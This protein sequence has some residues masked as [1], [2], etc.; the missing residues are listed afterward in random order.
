MRHFRKLLVVTA[1]CLIFGGTFLGGCSEQEQVYVPVTS[2]TLEVTEEGRLIAYIVEDF[3]KD[4]YDINELKDMVNAEIS[5]YN[6]ANASLST[7]AGRAPVIVDKVMMAEDGSRKAVVALNFQGI[8]AYMDYMG[9][10]VFF[11]TV[12]E[13]INAGYEMEGVLKAVKNGEALIGDKLK[14]NGEKKI[15][16]VGDEVTVRTYNAV[17]YLS[18]NASLTTNGYVDAT[19][20]DSLKYMIVK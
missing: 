16:I 6:E 19:A 15:L 11:G 9:E 4:Y 17:Q 20:Q 2:N 13:A 10:E 12:S 3:D 7:E 14:K 5:A 18:N 8:A 1:V